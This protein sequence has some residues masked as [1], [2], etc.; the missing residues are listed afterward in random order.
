[1]KLEKTQRGTPPSSTAGGGAG[2]DADADTELFGYG[3]DAAA[4]LLNPGRFRRAPRPPPT[5]P[6]GWQGRASTPGGGL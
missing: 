1:L 5:S 4:P 6:G 3:R 2:M